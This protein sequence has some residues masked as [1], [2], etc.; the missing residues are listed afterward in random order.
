MY[1]LTAPTVEPVSVSQAKAALRIDDTRFDALLPGLIS[2]ARAVAE[3]E[4]GRQLVNQVWRAELA[5]WPDDD[6]PL[7]VYRATACAITY[8]NGSAWVSLDGSGY[9]FAPDAIVGNGTCLAPALGSSW[10]ALGDIAL[11]PRVRV[12]LTAGVA[13]DQV[14]SV[15]AGICTF[16]TALVGQLI[17][18]P[19]LT[20]LQAVQAHPLL[21]RLL[22]PWRLY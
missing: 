3:Q 18:S 5:D 7:P 13:N 9:V 1:L 14:A 17:Q 16:I 2:A 10:P 11:G 20:A 21:A 22:D 6:D 8:W 15:P 12:D 4:T 19:E